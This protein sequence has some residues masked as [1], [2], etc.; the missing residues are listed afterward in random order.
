MAAVSSTSPMMGQAAWGDPGWGSYGSLLERLPTPRS[1]IYTL[2][3]CAYALFLL[4]GFWIEL[5][6][7]ISLAKY[8]AHQR[9]KFCS[10][11]LTFLWFFVY[12]SSHFASIFPSFYFTCVLSP[13][14]FPGFST[15]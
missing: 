14:T 4:L 3:I 10:F 11:S 2:F 13:D 7:S 12:P 6:F 1:V 9:V 5:F 15:P 8:L